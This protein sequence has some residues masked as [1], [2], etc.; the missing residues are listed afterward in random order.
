MFSFMER[1]SD[2][3]DQFNFVFSLLSRMDRR[4]GRASTGRDLRTRRYSP[5]RVIL[6]AR[7]PERDFVA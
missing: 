5:P 4:D 6:G 2:F 1:L 3:L 7:V